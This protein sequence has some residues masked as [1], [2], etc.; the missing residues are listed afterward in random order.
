MQSL[1]PD[2]TEVAPESGRTVPIP[3]LTTGVV[4]A[5]VLI[6][7]LI[8]AVLT[9]ADL[10]LV[11]TI[12]LRTLSYQYG[13]FWAGLLRGWTPNYAAQPWLMFLTHSF[14]HSGLSHLLGNMLALAL[15]A[16]HLGPRITGPAFLRLWAVSVLG[17]ALAFGFLAQSPRPMV[18]TSGALFGLVGALLALDLARRRAT[19]LPLWPALVWVPG[20]AALN[21]AYWWLQAGNL[22]WEAHL[23]GAVAGFLLFAPAALR[24][25][26]PKD[27]AA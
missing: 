18:G 10:G 23:G 25:R 3:R 4:A 9:A 12:R 13:G 26:P 6:C 8:E 11:S 17:G 1:Q 24:A 7:V 5:L 20:L 16:R 19:R 14:L 2:R 15:L 22:A 21:Y 27:D